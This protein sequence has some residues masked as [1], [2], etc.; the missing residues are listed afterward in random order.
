MNFSAV[1]FLLSMANIT[2]TVSGYLSIEATCTVLV[3]FKNRGLKKLSTGRIRPQGHKL[4][5]PDLN[6]CITLLS[7]APTRLTGSAEELMAT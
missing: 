5:V 2:L 1:N 7:T 3:L 4:H 6:S